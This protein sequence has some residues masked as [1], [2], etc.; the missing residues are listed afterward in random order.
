MLI[1]TRQVGETLL[2]GD[3]VKVTVLAVDG[4]QVKLG[5]S[6]PV[7]VVVLR[8]EI[9]PKRPSRTAT[10]GVNVPLQDRGRGATTR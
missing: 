8:Q 3:N 2:I 1:L 9:A 10:L 5:T 4:H 6:A 7:D